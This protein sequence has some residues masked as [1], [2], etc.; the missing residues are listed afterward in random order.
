MAYLGTLMRRG[1]VIGSTL[2]AWALLGAACGDRFGSDDASSSD[3]D[4][5]GEREGGVSDDGDPSDGPLDGLDD[6]GS[7]LDDDDAG[8]DDD[9]TG[10]GADLLDPLDGLVGGDDDDSETDGSMDQGADDQADP[11]SDDAPVDDADEPGGDQDVA[12]TDDG[13]AMGDEPATLDDDAPSVEPDSLSLPERYISSRSDTRLVFEIDSVP[14]MQ[15]RAQSEQDLIARFSALLDKPDGIEIRHDDS[16]ESRGED[17]VWTDDE[18]FAL[19]PDVF[20]DDEP[21]GT[22]T[23]HVMFLDGSYASDSGGTVLGV[24]WRNRHIA[25]FTQ[26]IDRSCSQV[27][28]LGG[29]SDEACRASEYGVWSHEV[30]HVLGLVNAGLPMQTDHEDAEHPKHDAQQGCLMYWAYD[31]P[32]FVDTTITRLGAGQ[33]EIDFCEPSLDDIRAVRQR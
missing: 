4:V 20:D 9:A 32:S 15:P 6:L 11:D 16:L 33:Q 3:A 17:Y 29:L 22:V 10:D 23:I 27:P 24:A 5:S 18:L 8:S 13:A 19:A 2:A 7:P 1:Q 12:T 21:S 14:G 30:G 31:G 28:L 26:T 25:M